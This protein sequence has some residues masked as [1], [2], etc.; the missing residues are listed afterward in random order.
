MSF[1]DDR[2]WVFNATFRVYHVLLKPLV[3]VLFY[4]QAPQTNEIL[5]FMKP[6]S[7]VWYVIPPLKTGALAS[8]CNFF[9]QVGD[10]NTQEKLAYAW[11]IACIG[12]N[13]CPMVASSGFYQSPGPPLLGDA[14][15]IVPAHRRGHQNGQESWSIFCCCFVCCC[16]GGCWGDMEQVVARWWCPVSSGVAL[17]MPYHVMLS[18]LLQRT[19][20][21]IKMACNGGALVVWSPFYCLP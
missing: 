11:P 9:V 21:A 19:C 5:T 17:D 18:V 15:G 13:S 1:L 7:C 4:S 2:L 20:M 16:P 8:T 3:H 12:R 14:C 10:E 6:C